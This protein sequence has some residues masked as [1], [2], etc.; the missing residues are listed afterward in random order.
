[1]RGDCDLIVGLLQMADAVQSAAQSN[2]SQKFLMMD[3]VYDQPL[4]N[5]RMQIFATD[6]AAFLAGYAAASVTRT[7]KVGVFG[8]I[9]IPPVTDFMDGFA[10]GARYYNQKNGVN[11]EVLGWG[12]VKHEGLFLGG[13]CC[14][15]EGRD[16]TQKLLDQGADII[17]PVAGT[18][19]GPGAAYAVQAHG[20]AYIIG[21]DTDWTM[22]NAEFT[23]IILTSILKNYDASVVQAV[24]AIENDTFSG[25]IQFGTLG[26]GEV[27]L[28]PFHQFDSLISPKV[29]AELEQIKADIIAG[30]IQT[31]P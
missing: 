2:P 3:Y 12:P 23:D 6:Q 16:I 31:K 9:D 11:V 26:T 1:M 17:L 21:V 10:L 25:G 29:K 30:T 8:G 28:A 24:Q 27:S 7:G 18:N 5:V 19:V 15:A 22:T 13:F 14:A 4:E 20:D